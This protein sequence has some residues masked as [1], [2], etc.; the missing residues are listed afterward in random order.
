SKKL[1]QNPEPYS[2]RPWNK[3]AMIME[4]L[5][6]YYDPRVP[7]K[8]EKEELKEEKT[9]ELGPDIALV[10]LISSYLEVLDTW[11]S[12]LGRPAKHESQSENKTVGT[13]KIKNEAEK[14]DHVNETNTPGIRKAKPEAYKPYQES[15]ERN[16]KDNKMQ[17]PWNKDRKRRNLRYEKDSEG[18][19]QNEENYYLNDLGRPNIIDIQAEIE[20]TEEVLDVSEKSA[21]GGKKTNECKRII[22]KKIETMRYLQIRWTC[23][24]IFDTGGKPLPEEEFD[25][26]IRSPTTV[27][28]VKVTRVNQNGRTP[29]E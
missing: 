29:I 14:T 27:L 28:Q 2:I 17:K 11:I 15:A 23:T 26:I 3:K 20:R 18:K 10:N 8:D 9:V 1:L 21:N 16:P 24:R 6:S 7:S 4:V 22:C 19:R 12:E 13:L 5:E 25:T